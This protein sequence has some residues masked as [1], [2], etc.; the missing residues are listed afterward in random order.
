MIVKTWGNMENK[1]AEETIAWDENWAIGDKLV[2]SQHKELVKLVNELVYYCACDQ[3][4]DAVPTALS[5]LVNY[6]V[7]HFNDEEALQQRCGFPYYPQH[8]QMH[9]DFKV[10][11]G[12]L[13]EKYTKQG[14]TLSLKNDLYNVLAAWL[15]NHII[16]ED[17][18]IGEYIK[19]SK[20]KN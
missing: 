1:K 4:K 19:N 12:G 3:M 13:V 14:S 18:K 11:V 2:D 5:F 16:N 6:A 8:K 9:E 15:V 7:T 17:K 10:T 20:P